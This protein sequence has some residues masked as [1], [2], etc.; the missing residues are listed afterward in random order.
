MRRFLRTGFSE[1]VFRTKQKACNVTRLPER[2]ITPLTAI[3]IVREFLGVDGLNK[4]RA[5]VRTYAF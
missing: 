4:P 3:R 5:E 1:L 2:L